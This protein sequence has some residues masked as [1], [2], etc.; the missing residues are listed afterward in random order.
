M[1]IEQP[2]SRQTQSAIGSACL[3]SDALLMNIFCYTGLTKRREIT[4]SPLS[5]GTRAEAKLREVSHGTLLS[6]RNIVRLLQD[7]GLGKVPSVNFAKQNAAKLHVNF[8]P[9]FW[10]RF[11]IDIQKAF[12]SGREATCKLLPYWDLSARAARTFR[13]S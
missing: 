1:V 13:I 4:L 9:F 5:S 2:N 3:T 7:G 8:T 10:R 6:A 12:E 11:H